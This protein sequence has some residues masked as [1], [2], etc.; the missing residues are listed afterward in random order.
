MECGGHSDCRTTVPY[1]RHLFELQCDQDT[2][3]QHPEPVSLYVGLGC[4]QKTSILSLFVS[5]SVSVSPPVSIVRLT[6]TGSLSAKD[7]P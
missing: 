7:L 4:R 3:S 5:L 2:A 1:S 6:P